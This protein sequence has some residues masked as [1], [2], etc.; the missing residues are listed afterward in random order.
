MD[1][2]NTGGLGVFQYSVTI[3]VSSFDSGGGSHPTLRGQLHNGL[4]N[5]SIVAY[6]TGAVNAIRSFSI[7]SSQAPNR[8]HERRIA[9]VTG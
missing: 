3:P 1:K 8:C 9:R 2:W 4:A 5:V 6:W 7:R